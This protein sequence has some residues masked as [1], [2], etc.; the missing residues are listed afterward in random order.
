MFAVNDASLCTKIASIEI[1]CCLLNASGPRSETTEALQIIGTSTA[2]AIVSKSVTMNRNDGNP[3]PRS[4][5]GIDLGK[6]CHGSLNSEG[7]PNAGINY[8]KM[9]VC[10]LNE[11]LK[12]INMLF[13]FRYKE[14]LV[15]YCLRIQEALRCISGRKLP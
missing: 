14:T 1:K 11:L 9:L 5:Q 12:Y 4:I 3:K 10:L 15:G 8:C 13:F 2:G 6:F 7:L